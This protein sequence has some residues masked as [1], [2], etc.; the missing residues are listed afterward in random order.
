MPKAI[1]ESLIDSFVC[2][3]KKIEWGLSVLSSDL[4]SQSPVLTVRL[5]RLVYFNHLHAKILF[6][7]PQR[8]FN[9]H[10]TRFLNWQDMAG[11]RQFNLGATSHFMGL[12]FCLLCYLQCIIDLDTEVS[13]CT[14]QLAM[15][16]QQLY[17]SEIFCPAINQ[18]CF[19][20]PQWMSSIRSW[21]KTNY[22]HPGCYDSCILPRGEMRWVFKSA[23]ES[24]NHQLKQVAWFGHCK[25]RS[26]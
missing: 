17:S 3:Y 12:H 13:D 9:S 23:F 10:S 22:R 6:Q 2:A 1:G 18:R 20:T 21:I 19:G 7:W 5:S 25:C 14:F 24:K 26:G 16:K 15:S 8:V 4:I 11:K